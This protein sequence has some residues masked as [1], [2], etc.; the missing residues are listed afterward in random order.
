MI[1][2][3]LWEPY[4]QFRQAMANYRIV[5]FPNR[6]RGIE[7]TCDTPPGTIVITSPCVPIAK[8]T[9]PDSLAV[10]VFN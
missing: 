3:L 9:I 5:R 4:T 6:G 10:Y 1:C 2:P 7:A 8:G